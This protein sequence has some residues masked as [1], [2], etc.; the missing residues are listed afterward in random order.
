M[1]EQL[2]K[3]RW[4]LEVTSPHRFPWGFGEDQGTGWQLLWEF[5]EDQHAVYQ[6]LIVELNRINDPVQLRIAD[7]SD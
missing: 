6:V 5:D 7:N 4:R 1:E 3:K 2:G